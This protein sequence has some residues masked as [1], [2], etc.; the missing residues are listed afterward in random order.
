[1]H[2]RHVMAL[3]ERRPEL[4][5]ELL[6]MARETGLYKE[7]PRKFFEKFFG[8]I[9]HFPPMKENIRYLSLDALNIIFEMSKE[10]GSTKL[11]EIFDNLNYEYKRLIRSLSTEI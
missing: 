11:M 2:S 1:M 3:L 6:R 10:F 9:M 4:A 7:L 8:R 5:F